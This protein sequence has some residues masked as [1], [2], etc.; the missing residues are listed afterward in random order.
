M[1]APW[2]QGSQCGHWKPSMLD[3]RVVRE[4]L[5]R[6]FLMTSLRRVWE[7]FLSPCSFP[8]SLVSPEPWDFLDL[9][10]FPYS[11][12]STAL[13]N[14]PLAV[15]T[16]PITFQTAT[17]GMARERAGRHGPIRPPRSENLRYVDDRPDVSVSLKCH[18][19][20]PCLI[21]DLF[22][23]HT[24]QT[25]LFYLKYLTQN[26]DTRRSFSLLVRRRSM[27]KLTPVSP[28]HPFIWLDKCADTH[29]A[30]PMRPSSLSTKRTT[31]LPISSALVF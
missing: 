20:L 30:C 11:S 25:W 2:Y 17:A 31:P 6:A 15:M 28:W 8:S 5:S 1:D 24:S 10:L 21:F 23:Y 19:L 3:C 4:V 22:F 13:A 14:L 16:S 18:Q 9:N 27:S 12:P 26:T 7:M 29:E